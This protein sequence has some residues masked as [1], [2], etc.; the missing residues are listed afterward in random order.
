[1][2]LISDFLKIC[3]NQEGLKNLLAV[4]LATTWFVTGFML[5]GQGFGLVYYFN[6]QKSKLCNMNHNKYTS[7]CKSL[8]QEW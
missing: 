8:G 5:K 2:P 7:F 1:L 4:V 3:S 6:P